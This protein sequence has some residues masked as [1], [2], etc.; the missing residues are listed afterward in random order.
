MKNKKS[1]FVVLILTLL[2]ALVLMGCPPETNP[3]SEGFDGAITING[4]PEGE[5]T[6]VL[7]PVSKVD[8]DP[9]ITEITGVLT[10]TVAMGTVSG[11]GNKKVDLTKVDPAFDTDG[12]WCVVVYKTDNSDYKFKSRVQ[13]TAGAASALTWSAFDNITSNSK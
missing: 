6:V 3:P 1:I 10:F 13:F 4:L 2:S 9:T 12:E 8:S 7:L 5:W 11:G